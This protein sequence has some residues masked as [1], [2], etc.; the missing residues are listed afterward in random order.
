MISWTGKTSQLFE[1][2][3]VR[4]YNFCRQLYCRTTVLSNNWDVEQ[5]STHIA[6]ICSTSQLF[7]N[8]KTC[9][10]TALSN[11]WLAEQVGCRTNNCR[12]IGKSNNWFSQLFDIVVVRQ[13]RHN[14]EQVNCR[15]EKERRNLCYNFHWN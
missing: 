4:Q 15:L 3:D 11:K 6:P 14:V 1:I 8:A 7:D 13:F 12:T 5:V 10:A 2:P 9:R